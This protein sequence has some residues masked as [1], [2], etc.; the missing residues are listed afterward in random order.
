MLQDIKK[1]VLKAESFN[2]LKKELL[3]LAEIIYK[4]DPTW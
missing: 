2:S 1:K 3:G 4:K